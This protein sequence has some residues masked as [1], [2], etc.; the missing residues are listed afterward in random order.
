MSKGKRIRPVWI[1]YILMALGLIALL[2]WSTLGEIARNPSREAVADLGPYGFITVRL[3]TDPYPARPTGTVKLTFTL[4]DSRPNI[5]QPDSLSF[6]Y[7]REGS[8]QIVGSGTAQS[9]S[10]GS[11]TLMGGAR[12]PSVGIWWLRV[13]LVKDGYQDDIQFTIEVRPAQ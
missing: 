5:I 1:F 4:I 3:Q 8:G 9:T 13:N 12:F 10:D 2:I 11:G 6:E 7:G